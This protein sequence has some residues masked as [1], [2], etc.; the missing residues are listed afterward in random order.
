MWNNE[1]RK[2]VGIISGEVLRALKYGISV[3]FE[4]FW[5]Q[6][7]WLY[8]SEVYVMGGCLISEWM[9]W[10]KSRMEE[11]WEFALL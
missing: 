2:K 4:G 8:G 5:V 9:E 10:S 3:R 11:L 1:R 6:F 7:K